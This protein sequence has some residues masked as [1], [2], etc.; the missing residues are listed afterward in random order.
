MI[1]PPIIERTTGFLLSRP[2]KVYKILGNLDAKLY[3]FRIPFE[4]KPEDTLERGNVHL[5]LTLSL[6]VSQE[7]T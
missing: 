6:K 5:C 3:F 1:K 7:R 2:Y 4:D